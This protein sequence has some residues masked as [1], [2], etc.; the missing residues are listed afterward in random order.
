MRRI[1]M[2]LW[3]KLAAMR[4]VRLFGLVT[5]YHRARAARTVVFPVC[6]PMRA[7]RR[8]LGSWRSLAW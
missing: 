1:M 6:L 7:V 4:R 5:A 8:G 3:R 2:V